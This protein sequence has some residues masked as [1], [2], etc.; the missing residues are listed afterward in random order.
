MFSDIQRTIKF[1]LQ[2]ISKA[3]KL[4][5]MKWLDTLMSSL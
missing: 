4:S 3:W 1:V 5:M 2:Q